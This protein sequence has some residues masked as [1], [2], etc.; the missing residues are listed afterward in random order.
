MKI[1]KDTVVTLK[2]KVSDAQG[3]LL[4][5]ADANPYLPVFILFLFVQAIPL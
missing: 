4:E 3:K 1:E 2:Y 5:A